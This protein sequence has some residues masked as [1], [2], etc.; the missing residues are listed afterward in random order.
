[1]SNP[2]NYAGSYQRIRAGGGSLRI[3][4]SSGISHADGANEGTSLPCAGCWV[5]AVIGNT[6]VV[7]M[8]IEAAASAILG[9]DL[10]RQSILDGTTEASA[11]ASQPMWVPIDDVNKLYFFSSLATAVIDI[12]YLKS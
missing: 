8:N 10:A 2:T 11:A 6:A 1:M 3:T 9:V 5:Q 12:T 7:K 4:L